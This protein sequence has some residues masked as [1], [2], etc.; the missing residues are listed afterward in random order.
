[1]RAA[2]VAAL[3]AMAAAT[4]AAGHARAGDGAP[5]GFDHIVHD[6]KVSVLGKDPIACT[7][8]HELGAAGTLIGRP[9]H[10][11]CLGACHAGPAPG[12]APTSAQLRVCTAC[13]AAA[14]LTGR[15][16]PRVAYPPYQLDPDYGLT[17]S[18]A[19]HAPRT[20]CT[21]CHARPGSGGKP[22]APH[23]RCASCHATTAAPAMTD[24]TGCHPAAYGANA[25]P[26]LERGPLAVGA[27]F[28][29]GRHA[30]RGPRGGDCAGCHRAIAAATG[31]EL[32]TP[33]TA[34]CAGCHDGAA[35]NPF[36]T[37]TA[38]TRC[39]TRAP[40][41]IFVVAHPTARFS[42]DAH[43]A[44]LAID[45]CATCHVLDRR[46]QP[47]P[48]GHAACAA[49]HA[50]DFAARAPTTCG[51]CHVATE[52][53]RP[54]RADR[55]PP[56]ASD[57]G[58]ELPHVAHATIACTTC[59]QLTTTTREL[60]PPRGHAACAGAGCHRVGAGPAPRLD[61]CSA[62]HQRGLERRREDD[63]A[64]RPWSVR[65][66]FRHD[67]HATDPRTATPLPCVTCHAGVA[68]AA[69]LAAIRPPGKPECAPCHDG[70]TA[71][72]LSGHGCA[73]CHGK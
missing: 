6:G 18:H 12:A 43:A 29:H 14:E 66:R 21:T 54:L 30:A 25:R 60:R 73:R 23:A 28:Q 59:H 24:C 55:L 34:D 46:G 61:A 20:P 15:G 26:R 40:A 3:V 10:A 8:C 58:V 70:K 68:A 2:I 13:H 65:A 7:R 47:A 56:P 9:G 71:F 31:L 50:D 22:P 64:A 44:R 69:A 42:H 32:P 4:L 27:A 33:T 53:W 37:T 57:F 48:A 35:G 63:G 16:R 67:R 1:M 72:K 52:P 17:L 5:L 36:A 19:A 51:A 45:A 39:H 38:C 49:C 62:C 41:E 11:A